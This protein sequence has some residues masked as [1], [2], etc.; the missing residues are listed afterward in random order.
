MFYFPFYFLLIGQGALFKYDALGS[1][2]RVTATVSGKGEELIQPI[3]DR[4]SK[5]EEN[6]ELWQ[7]ENYD[8]TEEIDPPRFVDTSI[9]S[10]IELVKSAFEAAAE[11]E[12][13]VG[14]GIQIVII[15]SDISSGVESKVSPRTRTLSFQLP[16]H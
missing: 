12:I 10:A 4:V 1:Y 7:F 11:R 14:D 9:D 8:E 2:E 16:K 15:E 3:L 6:K 13:S 5:M